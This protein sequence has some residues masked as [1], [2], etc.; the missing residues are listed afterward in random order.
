MKKF[1]LV[2]FILVD[3][4]LLSAAVM[5]LRYHLQSPSGVSTLKAPPVIKPPVPAPPIAP[6]APTV[7]LISISSKSAVTPPVVPAEAQ[8]SLN[9]QRKILFRYSNGKARQVSIRADFTGWK[10]EPMK[11]DDKGVWTYQAALTPGEY[12]YC[13]TVDDKTFK[14][15]ANK[16]T[17]QIGRTFV[18]AITVESLPV[19]KTHP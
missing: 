4:A 19:T 12:A 16:K 6:S 18:S 13:F 17:K 11:R 3:L 7:P 2:L 14:D 1:F 9:G 5:F 8:V 10:A 15:P